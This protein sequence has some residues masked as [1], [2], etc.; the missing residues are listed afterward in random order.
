M[1]TFW[2]RFT[3]F[4]TNQN[5]S[6]KSLVTY[7]SK[8]WI[9]IFKPSFRKRTSE[10]WGNLVT[11]FTIHE[12][13]MKWADSYI[14]IYRTVYLGWLI[15]AFGGYI[16]T[17][18]R[19]LQ[20]GWPCPFLTISHLTIFHISWLIHS[21]VYRGLCNT[22]ISLTETMDTSIL[23][24]P[25]LKPLHCLPGFLNLYLH[26]NTGI[27]INSFLKHRQL[28]NIANWLAKNLATIIY[29]RVY[30]KVLYDI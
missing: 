6:G 1:G 17:N 28:K 23:T 12:L 20:S 27:F 14:N 29:V 9:G 22:A 24:K 16:K 5:F 11:D 8:L 2:D 25:N 4:L 15:N 18:L 13:T 19:I 3:H 7:F 26:A 10:F 21:W 30:L